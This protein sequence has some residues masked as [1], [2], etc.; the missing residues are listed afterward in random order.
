MEVVESSDESDSDSD[1]KGDVTAIF[2]RILHILSVIPWVVVGK[3]ACCQSSVH[4]CLW[5]VCPV[6]SFFGYAAKTCNIYLIKC[7]CTGFKI[8]QGPSGA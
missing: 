4:N 1:E 2:Y 7:P 3:I 6:N 5:I 8:D